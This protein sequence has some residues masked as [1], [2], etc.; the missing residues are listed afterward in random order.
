MLK[1]GLR[2]IS[3][4]ASEHI[5]PL[6]IQSLH[7]LSAEAETRILIKL[8]QFSYWVL[9]FTVFSVYAA[10]L[11]NAFP[12]TAKYGRIAVT[13]ILWQIN[14][15]MG[16]IV[17]YLPN[18]LVIFLTVWLT[19]YILR[20][21]KLIFGAID[22]GS[23]AIPGFYPEWASPTAKLTKL[24]VIALSAALILPYLPGAD[25]P[26]FRGVS[27][28]LGALVALGGANAFSNL[29]G[30]FVIIYTRAFQIGDLIKFDDV[31]GIVRETT[32]LS[33]RIQAFT[34][35]VVTIPN[36]NLLAKRITNFNA[37]MRDFKQ[38][39]T[40]S[41]SIT[42]GY[43]VPWRQ[44]EA[45]LVA[46]ATAT[47]NILDDP[48]PYVLQTS[49]ND[50]YV[51]YEVRASTNTP[52]QMPKILSELHKQIQDMCNEAGI[53]IMSP[54]Y[55]AIRDGHH[56]TIPGEYLA[57]DYTP[58]GLRV[59]PLENLNILPRNNPHDL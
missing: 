44:V 35:E 37:N 30:G 6:Q 11:S 54:H 52:H 46:A 9:W 27:L 57:P 25:S 40:L 24:V 43:D 51:S 20:F 7:L 4:W 48:A 28:L 36:A 56:T 33:T 59:N 17:S 42:L 2:R 50:F 47:P 55:A 5:Q 26:A 29:I 21:S 13:F 38:P 45:V 8:I 49:L 34:G 22:R 12:W 23:L 32:I 1:R 31:L 39:L 53:E 3:R 58:P 19:I 16:E 14:I 41:T 18:L 10:S 15:F